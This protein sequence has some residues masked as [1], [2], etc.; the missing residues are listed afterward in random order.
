MGRALACLCVLV[1]VSVQIAKTKMDEIMFHD[2]S[3]C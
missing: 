2:K 3:K 1:F